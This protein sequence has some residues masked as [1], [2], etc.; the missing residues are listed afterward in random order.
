MKETLPWINLAV[1]VLSSALAAVLYT[2]SV[3]PEAWSRQIGPR[4]YLLSGKLR[5]LAMVFMFTGLGNYLLY[6]FFPLPIGMPLRLPW[7]YGLSLCLAI[8]IAIPAGYFLVRGVMDAGEEAAMPAREHVLF[9]G[10]YERLRH[11]QAWEVMIW[12]VLAFLLH[13][14]FLVLYSCLWL[15]LEYWMVMSEEK[16]LLLR[17]GREYKSYQKRTPAFFPRLKDG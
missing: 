5:T 16:D 3:R 8:L 12:F 13:S 7:N 4:A 10:V 6:F 15:P 17:Y 2:R 1:L 11:P 14:P 9:S